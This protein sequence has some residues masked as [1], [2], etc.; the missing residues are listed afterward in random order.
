[1]EPV[2]GAK[3][4][5]HRFQQSP[6]SQSVPQQCRCPSLLTEVWKYQQVWK[7][8]SRSVNNTPRIAASSVSASPAAQSPWGCSRSGRPQVLLACIW[9]Q[10]G[11]ERGR[12][13]FGLSSPLEWDLSPH[14]A[15]FSRQPGYS[16]M[17]APGG[18]RTPR[19]GSGLSVLKAVA[20]EQ[21]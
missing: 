7:I 3:L 16:L 15:G 4:Q 18:E 5:N 19:Q 6:S 20:A 13:K 21:G 9:E 8:H 1:M 10:P 14:P 11:G 12:L 2:R 17:A